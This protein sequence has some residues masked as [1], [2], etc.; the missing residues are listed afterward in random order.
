MPPTEEEEGRPLRCMGE[1]QRGML[2][3]V[4]AHI[5]QV[6]DSHQEEGRVEQGK[7]QVVEQ[8]KAELGMAELGK[9]LEGRQHQGR[10]EVQSCLWW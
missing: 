2:V 9:Q 10:V 4:A 6:M 5:Q 1:D 3:V 7:E 8:G